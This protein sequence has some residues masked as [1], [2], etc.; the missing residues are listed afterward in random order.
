MQLWQY[1][2]ANELDTLL[3][4]FLQRDSESENMIS[5]PNQFE[6]NKSEYD[7]FRDYMKKKFNLS[8]SNKRDQ[9]FI[10]MYYHL[11]KFSL[12][13]HFNKIQVNAFVYTISKTH[14]MA[15]STAYGPIDETHQYMKDMLLLFSVNRPPFSL[16]LFSPKQIKDCL[17][18][19]LATYFRH[20]KLYKLI[21]TPAIKLDLQFKYTNQIQQEE[22]QEQEITEQETE[23]STDHELQQENKENELIKQTSEEVSDE[24]KE[25]NHANTDELRHFIRKYLSE[26]MTK[27]KKEM[28]IF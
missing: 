1:L 11:I 27:A 15:I 5:D 26:E 3:A 20:F 13:Q 4:C 19:F 6:K 14:E 2:N 17:D 25:V 16:E 24:N 23:E 8:T 28:D 18:Y 10:D 7:L 9:I 21:F 12:K 22:N